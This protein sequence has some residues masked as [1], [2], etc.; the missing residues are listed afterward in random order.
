MQK[1][2][3][4]NQLK[5][6]GHN[7]PIQ[8]SIKTIVSSLTEYIFPFTIIRWPGWKQ[9]L[10]VQSKADKHLYLYLLGSTDKNKHLWTLCSLG[11]MML[12]PISTFFLTK[13]GMNL[14]NIHDVKQFFA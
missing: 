8:S 6:D 9:K 10:L 11:I 4:S 14:I 7:L 13:F 1:T 3:F 5:S 2:Q 12:L